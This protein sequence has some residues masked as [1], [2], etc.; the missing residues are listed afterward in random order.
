MSVEHEV[1]SG[2]AVRI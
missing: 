1:K 2:T